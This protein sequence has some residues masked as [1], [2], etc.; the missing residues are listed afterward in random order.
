[1]EKPQIVQATQPISKS[2]PHSTQ[3][4]INISGQGEQ[5]HSLFP[6]GAASCD[7]LSCSNISCAG[8]DP[9]CVGMCDS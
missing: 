9:G 7:N 1:M 3:S 8:A 5:I 6:C 4:H 2:S